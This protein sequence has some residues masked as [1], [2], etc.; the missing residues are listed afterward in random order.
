ML[1]CYFGGL[2]THQSSK[3]TR[4]ML[5]IL[6]LQTHVALLLW[7]VEEIGIWIYYVPKHFKLT[8]VSHRNLL[9]FTHLFIIIY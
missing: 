1:P 7:Q 2:A 8:F 9:I 4:K 3:A 5:P 6:M